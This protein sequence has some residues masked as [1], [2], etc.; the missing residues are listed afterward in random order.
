M[1]L[2]TAIALIKENIEKNLTNA[3]LIDGFTLDSDELLLESEIVYWHMQVTNKAGSDKEKYLVWNFGYVN[4][5][6]HGDGQVLAFDY[7][8]TFT[9]YSNNPIVNTVLSNI[10][11]E[12]QKD[13]YIMKFDRS[14]YDNSSQLYM[15]SFSAQNRVSE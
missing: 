15:Y 9:L 3:G 11:T 5:F 12:L 7:T 6:V 13:R 14:S 4:P 1:K 10:E 2:T 8:V